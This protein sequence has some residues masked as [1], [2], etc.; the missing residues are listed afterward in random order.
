MDAFNAYVY[1]TAGWMA[2]QAVGLL[3]SPKFSS[4]VLSPE[5]RSPTSTEE[6]LARALGFSLLALAVLTVLLTG[7]V[8]LTSTFAENVNAA[9]SN[10]KSPYAVPTVTV[11]MCFQSTMAFY[12]YSQYL[13]TG[14]SAF[15][16]DVAVYGGLGAM[17]LWCLL[18]ARSGGKISRTG[19]DKRTSGF[20]FTNAEADKR[21]VGKKSL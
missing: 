20:P 1:S 17:G 14:L 10:S 13:H 2:F 5:T 6:Y 21:K 8:P 9:D 18:F 16:L 3:I 12:C 15:A 7:T 4:A 19:A 11:S